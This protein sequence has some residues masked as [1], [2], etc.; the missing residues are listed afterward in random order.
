MRNF[1][2]KPR[3]IT[4][5]FITFI[6]VTGT[7]IGL[8]SNASAAD[9]TVSFGAITDKKENAE[10]VLEVT[11]EAAAPVQYTLIGD[12]LPSGINH[13]A[14][15]SGILNTGSN[16]VEL[17]FSGNPIYLSRIDGPYQISLTLDYDN[18]ILTPVN[19]ITTGIYDHNDFKDEKSG[20]S[21]YSLGLVSNTVRLQTDVFTAVIYE[22][23]PVIEYYY[24]VDNGE[25]AKFEVTYTK[26]I[27][28]RDTNG[29]GYDSLD[30]V[31]YSTDLLDASW[32][33]NKALLENFESFDF[34]VFSSV[35]L[36]SSQN[37]DVDIL[38]SFHYSSA[39]YTSNSQRKF[40]I[41]IQF[42]DENPLEGVDALVIEQVLVDKSQQAHSFVFDKNSNRIQFNNEA[43]IEHGYYSWMATADSN[44]LVGDIDVTANTV[45][46]K[47]GMTLYLSYSYDDSVNW[48]FHDPEIGIN[49]DNIQIGGLVEAVVKV[50]HHPAIYIISA[51]IAAGI[52][53]SS[54]FRSRKK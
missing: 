16:V 14:T 44:N 4:L 41:D 49:P 15:A 36:E 11:I 42:L 39:S 45:E 2:N 54:M 24:S 29:D 9:E 20:T 13:K 18:V 38:I 37:A 50:L 1:S 26:L 30:P 3:K 12:M 52:V 35:T 23:Q 33:S 21:E 48:I 5:F 46:M 10:L 25:T 19:Y 6:V 34:E 40:D 8:L 22:Y 47:N 28:Y 32:N 53:M 27:G 31:I 7:F 17:R 43:G 51:M